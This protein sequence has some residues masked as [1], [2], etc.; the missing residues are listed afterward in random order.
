MTTALAVAAESLVV[1]LVVTC[2][3]LWDSL[4]YAETTATIQADVGKLIRCPGG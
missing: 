2:V 1:T 3:G 4:P